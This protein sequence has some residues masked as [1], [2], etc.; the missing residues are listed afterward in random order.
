MSEDMTDSNVATCPELDAL[1]QR[2]DSDDPDPELIEAVDQHL[3]TCRICQ[4]AEDDL[5]RAV[6]A[7]RS[8]TPSEP[9][10]A[11]EQALVERLCHDRDR[12]DAG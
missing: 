1:I 6:V 2:C 9:S 4:R 11:F 10:A 5:T 3:A 8:V 12:N 7:Y